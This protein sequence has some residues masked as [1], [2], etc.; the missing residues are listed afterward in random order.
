MT[1]V[2]VQPRLWDSASVR[3]ASSTS[4]TTRKSAA[5]GV[6]PLPAPVPP[7]THALP[8]Q[9]DRPHSGGRRYRGTQSKKQRGFGIDK[10]TAVGQCRQYHA[11][12]ARRSG[13]A[14]HRRNLREGLSGHDFRTYRPHGTAIRSNVWRNLPA[15]GFSA[16]R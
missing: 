6:H 5:D 15:S 10:R 4:P 12:R 1:V 3:S 9:A 13:R 14:K 8:Q 2:E 11:F 7:Q 16:Y